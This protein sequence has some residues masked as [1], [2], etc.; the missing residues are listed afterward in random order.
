MPSLHL[1]LSFA[2]S[3]DDVG[4]LVGLGV[5]T[6]VGP[7]VGFVVGLGVATL[8][9]L[10]VGFVV[11]LVVGTFVGLDVDTF[12][13]LTLALHLLDLPRKGFTISS[14][15]KPTQHVESS[16]HLSFSFAHSTD[17]V[18]SVFELVLVTLL[19]VDVGMLVVLDV[20][21]LVWT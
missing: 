8:V 9:R 11:G 10:D 17:D 19:I 13:E 18:A 20:G 1:S 4:A 6:F 14:H 2:H 12:V 21:M 16:L 15:T 5:G 3:T 7:G